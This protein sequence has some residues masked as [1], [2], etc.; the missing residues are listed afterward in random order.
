MKQQKLQIS[1]LLLAALL[2]TSCSNEN[3]PITPIDKT[4]AIELGITAGVSL[5]KSAIN[6]GDANQNGTGNDVMQSVAVYATGTDGSYGTSSSNNYAIYKQTTGTWKNSD[7]SHKIY[8]TSDIADIY[9]Y[10]PAYTPTNAGV[11]Q[12]SGTALQINS[13][14]I[15]SGFSNA[16]INIS[17]YPGADTKEANNTIPTNIENA[18]QTYSGGWQTNDNAGKIA[19]APGEVDY[20]WAD[21][22]VSA[23][24]KASN[25]KGDTDVT[26]EKVDLNMKHAMAMVSFRI[27]NDG[28]YALPG[29][30]TQ[31]TLSNKSGAV[32]T[33]GT[34]PVMKIGDGTVTPGSAVSVD[35]YTRFIGDGLNLVK[36]NTTANV[37][38]NGEAKEASK[39]F[40]ILVMPETAVSNKQTVKVVFKIDNVDYDVTLPDDASSQWKQGENYL[41]TVK[42]SG[43]ELSITSVKVAKWNEKKIDGDL[44]V[45]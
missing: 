27:Y 4:D 18:D 24:M 40:S 26:D 10:H 28:T 22:S 30:L 16:T 7:E 9:A 3:D 25:G 32:L 38:T 41:Y 29:K 43:K 20:M 34:S 31:I 6:G 23:N 1:Y 39:K 14:S 36:V 5:T 21:R 13:A 42:L 2:G 12:S 17:V 15:G 11:M 37:T 19:S 33:K 35:S 8:L 45:N 44:N